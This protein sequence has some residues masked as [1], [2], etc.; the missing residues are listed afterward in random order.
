LRTHKRSSLFACAWQLFRGSKAAVGKGTSVN[1]LFARVVFEFIFIFLFWL[2]RGCYI[3]W[4]D[5]FRWLP[6]VYI[7]F[8]SPES[9]TAE[10]QNAMDKDVSSRTLE[11]C[12]QATVCAL[13]LYLTLTTL[14]P[15]F[16]PQAE[17]LDEDY[18]QDVESG[19]IMMGSRVEADRSI[20][21]RWKFWSIP[22]VRYITHLIMS[23]VFWLLLVL[24]LVVPLETI[25]YDGG[26]STGVRVRK[27]AYHVVEILYILCAIGQMVALIRVAYKHYRRVEKLKLRYVFKQVFNVEFLIA[28]L[29]LIALSCRAMVLSYELGNYKS[30]E[31]ILSAYDFWDK[32]EN[33]SLHLGT[34]TEVEGN[35]LLLCLLLITF[36][37]VFDLKYFP[38]FGQTT[39][40][41]AAMIFESR[42]VV[43]LMLLSCGTVM[44]VLRSESIGG[45]P[46]V[47][48]PGADW[49]EVIRRISNATELVQLRAQLGDSGSGSMLRPGAVQGAN[50]TFDDLV[51][52]AVAREIARSM[53]ADNTEPFEGHVTLPIWS[54]VGD[55]EDRKILWED[56]GSQRLRIG[57][58][59]N[60]LTPLLLIFFTFLVMMFLVNLM[61]AQMST[62]YEYIRENSLRFRSLQLVDLTLEFKDDR[63]APSPFNLF[64]G[65]NAVTIGPMHPERVL[66]SPALVEPPTHRVPTLLSIVSRSVVGC[67]EVGLR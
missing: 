52:L 63:G 28:A 5:G 2:P 30:C 64:D 55:L 43:I 60:M 22:K 11:V 17:E 10:D 3:R 39:Q 9:L 35:S 59:G 56:T 13:W 6:H 46:I 50:A 4:L 45:L 25:D 26:G 67:P 49:Q 33:F 18:F 21:E 27:G 38:V 66:P 51:T 53:R 58:W 15:C 34:L 36:R 20:E 24:M 65:L 57:R 37:V 23:V 19:P 44:L 47:Q 12:S 29:N 48:P 1:Q 16:C 61:I 7:P 14:R 40:I 62:R 8:F 31:E 54:L 41:L 42:G 32:C